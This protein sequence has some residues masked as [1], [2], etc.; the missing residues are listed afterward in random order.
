MA[1][2]RNI[3]VHH[4]GGL[5][6]NNY[7]SSFNLT[8]EQVNAAHKAR[9]NF[10][11]EYIENSYGGYNFIYDPKTGFFHQY[12]AIGEETAAQIGYNFDT[13]SICI[14]GNYSINPKTGTPVDPLTTRTSENIAKLILNLISGEHA[15]LIK[16][17]TKIDLS[18]SRAFPHRH[19]QP[20]TECYGTGLTNSWIQDVLAK[21][22]KVDVDGQLKK[23]MFLEREIQRLL[24]QIARLREKLKVKERLGGASPYDR[25]CE[26]FIH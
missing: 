4:S 6:N 13:V 9:W 10:P 12:R 18:T 17:G 5:G 8:W 19:Y 1:T 25:E 3:A 21:Y 26:G 11:S 24:L 23:R 16:P 22:S 20:T 7:A 14:I 15:Y 2:I